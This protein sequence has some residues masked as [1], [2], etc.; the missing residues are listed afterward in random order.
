MAIKD[1]RE[2][3]N[4]Y[5]KRG[6][7]LIVKVEEWLEKHSITASK[8]DSEIVN[9][10]KVFFIDVDGD[11]LLKGYN[12]DDIANIPKYIKFR[13]VKGKFVLTNDK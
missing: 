3:K 2:R 9:G 8:I 6:I 5:E 7:G 12:L 13:D 1:Y 4:E 10:N 11:V